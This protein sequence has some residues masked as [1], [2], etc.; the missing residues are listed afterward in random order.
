MGLRLAF[1]HC[2]GLAVIALALESCAASSPAATASRQRL[3]VSEAGAALSVRVTSRALGAGRVNVLIEL[4]AAESLPHVTVEAASPDR[5]AH[6]SGTCEYTPL[7]PV[8]FSD[9]S[10]GAGRR[11]KPNPLPV[12]PFCSFVLFAAHAGTYP[13]DIHIRGAQDRELLA[14]IRALIRVSSARR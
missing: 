14:P 11:R 1:G 10:S 6:V 4:R 13:L 7:R 5:R 2:V 9:G 3:P 12:V 8:V